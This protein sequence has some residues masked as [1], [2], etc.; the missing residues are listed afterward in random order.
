MADRLQKIIAAY[1]LASRR[2]AE[3][4][5]V[6]GLVT[7]NG[8]V[9]RE[10][11]TRADPAVDTILVA[12]QQLEVTGQQRRY[13]ILHKP[14]GYLTT[15]DDP[16]G[17]KIVTDLLTGIGDRVYPVGRLDYQ[18]SGLLL[19][20]ND[21]ELAHR[22]MHPR[23]K[24]EKTYLVTVAG[25]FSSQD[26]DRLARGIMLEDG[27]SKPDRTK[28]LEAG[29]RRSILEMVLREGRNRQIRRT[30][31][32]MGFRVVKLVRTRIGFLSLTGL[33]P[34]RYRQLTLHEVQR[35]RQSVGL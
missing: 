21:G 23:Y 17:R 33:V 2:Q 27:I 18:S 6:Q 28:L 30:L 31:A 24:L 25:Y 8:Q 16:Q 29:R 26:M 1:G 10:L 11:G 35:V 32:A 20:T 14:A 22:M 5:I 4:L 15:L 13:L 3:K 7:V 34:G 12:G 9:V 19:C